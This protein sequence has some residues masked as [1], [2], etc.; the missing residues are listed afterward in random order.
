MQAMAVA[1]AL[2][3]DTATPLDTSSFVSRL[4]DWC[5]EDVYRTKVGRFGSLLERVD[6]RLEVVT[7]LGHGIEAFNSVPTA[8]FSFLSHPSDFVSTVTYA[9]SLGGDT[10]T[11]AS[12]A[13]AISG[14]YLG[15]GALPIEWQGRLENRDYISQLADRLWRLAVGEGVP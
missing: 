11:I 6:E 8:I 15:V 7:E 13:G 5:T 1:M 3:E 9:I 10:D 12:M 14:A 4:Q 2:V